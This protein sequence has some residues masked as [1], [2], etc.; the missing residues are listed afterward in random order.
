MG[1]CILRLQQYELLMKGL[2]ANRE[3][4]GYADELEANRVTRKKEVETKMLGQLIGELTSSCFSL[5]A[6]GSQKN[7]KED[8]SE[9]DPKQAHVQMSYQIEM[10]EKDYQGTTEGLKQLVVLRNELVHHFL[11]RFKLRDESGC[12]EAN[13]YLDDAY[14]MIEKHFRDLRSW[15]KAME[16]ARKTMGELL[17]TSEFQSFFCMASF[18]GRKLTGP[19]RLLSNT[20][21]PPNMTIM[22]MAG[23]A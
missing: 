7:T 6:N 12:N 5:S 21:L 23:Q 19:T 14:Q 3:L 4:S 18:L 15:M 13:A 9:A 10:H 11:E 16:H 1:R 17:G 22:K 8:N 20:F 2:I